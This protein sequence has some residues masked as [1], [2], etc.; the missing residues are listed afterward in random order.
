MPLQAMTLT[1]DQ[2]MTLTFVHLIPTPN[3][4]IYEPK[5]VC[6]QDWVKFP[7]LV[8]ETYVHKVFGMHRLTHSF[9]D[10]WT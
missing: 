10:R 4:H 3:Q 8:F 1:F 9:T 6:D 2:A 5:Y 7:S